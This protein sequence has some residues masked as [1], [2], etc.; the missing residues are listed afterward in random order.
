[1][2]ASVMLSDLEVAVISRIRALSAFDAQY[3]GSR[4]YP[5]RSKC[6]PGTRMD[7]LDTISN[8]VHDKSSQYQIMWLQGDPGS[9]KSA[10][11]YSLAHLESDKSLLGTFFFSHDDPCCNNERCLFINIALY[12]TRRLHQS[13]GV[14]TSNIVN[15]LF[16]FL[17][18]TREQFQKLVIEPMQVF[19]DTNPPDRF[20]LII[21]GLDECRGDEIQE[22]IVMLLGDA[23]SSGQLPLRILFTSQPS[24]HLM[25]AFSSP[26]IG[27]VTRSLDL[28][29]IN[30]SD[31]IRLFVKDE[32]SR[33]Y[34]KFDL[35]K[36]HYPVSWPGNDVIEELV[37]RSSGLFLYPSIVLQY[38][39]GRRSD[40]PPA[41][42]PRFIRAWNEGYECEG[43]FAELDLLY[44]TILSRHSDTSGTAAVLAAMDAIH[45]EWHRTSQS[46]QAL[47]SPSYSY[48]VSSIIAT[49][50]PLANRDTLH[51]LHPSVYEFVRD[52]LRARRF[53]V[54]SGKMHV[55][56]TTGCLS[57]IMEHGNQ[58]LRQRLEDPLLEVKYAANNWIY[59]IMHSEPTVESLRQWY[60]VGLKRRI[61]ELAADWYIPFSVNPAEIA[62]AWPLSVAWYRAKRFSPHGVALSS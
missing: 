36:D 59:H 54:P 1:M 5:P 8:W 13:R 23:I 6:H 9:G 11:A 45:Y 46:L 18:S 53:Y 10:I 56:L 28:G 52:P 12:I 43:P 58:S 21:D 22:S 7:I 15:D 16:I 30:A 27:K 3:N 29:S 4:R 34:K 14:I 17:R 24:P 2:A 61:W 44:H 33:I 20:L 50:R 48:D 39:A 37:S 42:L 31:D 25:A 55:D 40:I 38:I 60:H 26:A 32:F 49:M 41:E 51:I 19:S 35:S 62:I 47:L 57:I